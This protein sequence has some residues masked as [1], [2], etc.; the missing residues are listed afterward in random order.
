[1]AC[2]RC[3]VM[4]AS[5]LYLQTAEHGVRS[6]VR[7]IFGSKPVNWRYRISIVCR[8]GNVAQFQVALPEKFTFKAEDWP[9]WIKCFDRFCVASG[10][11]TQADENQ[12]SVLI[13]TMGEEAED[14]LVSLYTSAL[15]MQV[16]TR[17]SKRR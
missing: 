15:K 17:P 8:C 14:I 9:K 13:Y 5:R 7:S 3:V 16:S 11:E 1:M 4:Y 6:D 10:L 12:V 2:V